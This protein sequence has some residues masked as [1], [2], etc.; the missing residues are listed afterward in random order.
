MNYYEKHREDLQKDFGSEYDYRYIGSAFS[1]TPQIRGFDG[2]FLRRIMPEKDMPMKSHSI[3]VIESMCEQA[4]LNAAEN[5]KYSCRFIIKEIIPGL[6]PVNVKYAMEELFKRLVS[7]KGILC[8]A[9]P[10]SD[11]TLVIS[12]A[13]SILDRTTSNQ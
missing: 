5:G 7:R 1:T 6:P 12:W 13:P 10:K 9:D 2:T 11:D 4:M 8:Y 3:D